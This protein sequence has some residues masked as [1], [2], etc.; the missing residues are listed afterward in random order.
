MKYILLSVI[1]ILFLNACSTNVESLKSKATPLTFFVNENYQLVYRRVAQKQQCAEGWAGA[2]A[3][4][5]VNSQLYPDLGFGEIS[6]RLTNMGTNNFYTYTEI[7]KENDG[8]RVVIYSGNQ[9]NSSDVA[10]E[11]ASVAKG[12]RSSSC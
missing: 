4:F 7:K 1:S 8:A 6:L 9:V 5:N 10:K 12:E 2:F 11:I 3:T